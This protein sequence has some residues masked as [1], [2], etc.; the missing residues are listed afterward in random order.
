MASEYKYQTLV[1]WIKDKVQAGELRPNDKLISENRLS[2]MFSISRQTVRHAISLLVKEGIVNSRHGSGNYISDK[3]LKRDKGSKNIAIIST[4]VN[5]YIFPKTIEG[6]QK[7]LLS[8][9]YT[10]QIMFTQNS[11]D[12]EEAI[13]RKLIDSKD[14]DGLIIEPTKSAI[15]KVDYFI[16]QELMDRGIPTIFF[17]SFYPNLPIHHVSINDEMAGYMATKYLLD[18]GHRSIGGIFKSDDGQGHLRYK[19]Y[20][21]ALREAG[22]EINDERI[23][24]IDSDDQRNFLKEEKRILRRLKSCTACLCYND[25]VASDLEIICLQNNVEVPKE[26]SLVSVDN[27]DVAE[28]CMV[29]LTSVIHPMRR[30]GKKVAENLLELIE[31]VSFPGTYEFKPEIYQRS[32]VAELYKNKAEIILEG[33]DGSDTHREG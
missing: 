20:L 28:L 18:A 30:L 5:D 10:V 14:I 22:L 33:M 27:S 29:P 6:M 25:S 1:E 8:K 13:I 21:K 3:A 11:V 31:D 24:W 32:S 9:G 2:E 12:K 26:L 4:Y 7:V 19:G 16:Y 17:N 23:I 15:P